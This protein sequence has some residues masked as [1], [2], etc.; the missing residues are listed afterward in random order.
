MRSLTLKLTLAFLFVGL[1]GAVLVAIFVGLRARSEFDRFVLDAY[2]ADLLQ[3]VTTYY[4]QEGSWENIGAIV[5]RTPWRHGPG[6]GGGPDF[7]RAPVVLADAE[8]AVVYGGSSYQPGQSLSRA[9]LTRAIP[10]EVDGRMVGRLMFEPTAFSSSPRES[11]E[12]AFLQRINR[13]ILFGAVGAIIAALLIGILLARGISRPV[14][15]LTLA[16]QAVAQ[17][18][19]GRQVEVRTRDEIGELA[20]SFNQM[21]TDLARGTDLRRQM[22]A[23]IAHDLRT[24]LSVILGYTEALADG[25]LSGGPAMY[26]VMHSEALHLQR[27]IDDLRTLSLADA[28]ELSLS[29]VDCSPQ[30]LLERAA[31]AHAVVVAEK[32]VDLRVLAAPSLPEVKVDPERMA[33]VLNNLVS[34]AVRF[35]PGGGS[36]TL[37]AEAIGNEVRLEVRDTGIGIAAADLPNVFERF[38]RGDESRSDT[39]GESGLGLAIAKSLTE[40]HGGRINVASVTGQG[41]AFSIYLPGVDAPRG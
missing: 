15:E 5:V 7:R 23:D 22:T 40:A 41:T 4:E 8:G 26:G 1:I 31:A 33:Q 16:T 14:R 21:S 35:T 9:D 32:G 2:Q 36:I 27:L 19:L 10:I 13:A 30:S 28:G 39:E 17:G 18:E 20:A 37:T 12:A 6:G 3:I 29:L 25:K 11:P 38:Y 34:N 24:P